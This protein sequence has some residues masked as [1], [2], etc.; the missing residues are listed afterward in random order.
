MARQVTKLGYLDV[1]KTLFMLCDLQDKFRPGMKMFDPVVKN[2]S[3]LV[4]AHRSVT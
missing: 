2:T 1:K 3:K 4:S